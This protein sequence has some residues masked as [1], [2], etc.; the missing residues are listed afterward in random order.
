MVA[1]LV[2]VQKLVYFLVSFLLLHYQAEN[3]E[4][5]LKN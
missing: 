3:L 5:V 2:Q 1:I 4:A